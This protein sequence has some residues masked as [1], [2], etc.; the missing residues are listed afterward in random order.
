MTGGNTEPG[1]GGAQ[2][3]LPQGLLEIAGLSM[4]IGDTQIL[5]DISFQISRGEIFGLVGESGSGKSMSALAAMGLLPKSTQKT[6]NIRFDGTDIAML[7]DRQMQHLR[8]R[9]I[10]MIFQEP[11]SALN[12]LHI[13]GAQIAETLTVH[14]QLS[15]LAARNEACRLLERVGLSPGDANALALSPGQLMRIAPKPCI[16]RR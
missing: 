12:P 13:V 7:S 11:M 10:G 15:G 3:R 4:Q 2:A 16:A 8:G 14:S 5:R 6:G 9:E 1:A